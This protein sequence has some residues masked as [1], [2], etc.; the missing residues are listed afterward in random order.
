MNTAPSYD[1]ATMRR[2]MAFRLNYKT[3]SMRAIE[4]FRATNV[5]LNG[6]NY[7]VAVEEKR[8]WYM[9]NLQPFAVHPM[10]IA[11]LLGCRDITLCINCPYFNTNSILR[12]VAFDMKLRSRAL[13]YALEDAEAASYILLAKRTIRRHPW[14]SMQHHNIRFEIV[15]RDMHYRSDRE[16]REF[17]KLITFH[18]EYFARQMIRGALASIGRDLMREKVLAVCMGLH[19]RLGAACDFATLPHELVEL[20]LAMVLLGL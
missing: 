13:H 1:L 16:D 7:H 8:M 20:V 3:I 14:T 19:P 11:V 5:M 2:V 15:H 10:T 4:H 9:P 6:F 18:H 12:A 17:H